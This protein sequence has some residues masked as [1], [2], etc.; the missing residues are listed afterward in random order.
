MALTRADIQN[1][2]NDLLT[3]DPTLTPD[4]I[5]AAISSWLDNFVL[6]NAAFTQAESKTR[7]LDDLISYLGGEV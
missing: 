5:K 7:L 3:G 6:S 4:Q 1:K 2:I